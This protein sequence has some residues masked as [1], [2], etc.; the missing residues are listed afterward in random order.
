MPEKEGSSN[1]PKKTPEERLR[2]PC[3][4]GESKK[5]VKNCPCAGCK[6]I[7]KEAQKGSKVERKS[8]AAP[9]PTELR[10]SRRNILLL[11]SL[12]ATL[13]ATTAGLSQKKTH[14]KDQIESTR[15]DEADPTLID[16]KIRGHHREISPEA[17]EEIV[18]LLKKHLGVNQ[19]NQIDEKNFFPLCQEL[20]TNKSFMEIIEN[21]PE[22]SNTHI[23]LHPNLVSE[24]LN[25]TL[26]GSDPTY[27]LDVDVEKKT[28]ALY[29]STAPKKQRVQFTLPGL[30]KME[31]DI[32]VT[33]TTSDYPGRLGGG[34]LA[35]SKIILVRQG[36]I[37]NKPLEKDL[38]LKTNLTKS[39]SGHL[40]NPEKVLNEDREKLTITHESVHIWLAAQYGWQERNG[41]SPHHVKGLTL[42][43]GTT[44]TFQNDL[45]TIQYNEA[46]A[47]ALSNSSESHSDDTIVLSTSGNLSAGIPHYS[48][49]KGLFWET[50]YAL[51]LTDK[52]ETP[53]TM[54]EF[55]ERM[56]DLLEKNGASTL[57]FINRSIAETVARSL[58]EKSPKQLFDFQE[59]P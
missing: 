20:I 37:H 13:I 43:N 41:L 7:K 9:A 17:K 48:L 35:N 10:T 3:P 31:Q 5:I 4:F 25:P 39:G 32:W 18:T 54:E 26:L 46:L 11:L 44:I 45:P 34:V 55:I 40:Y 21:R 58:P 47:C 28:I 12:S 57:R 29:T 56:A 16:L 8:D 50:A 30:L 1:L 27:F 22:L 23:T 2:E 14:E 42:P 19:E 33:S 15:K 53:L 51:G 38:A 52:K 24:L 59:K 6:E 36:V 49:Y